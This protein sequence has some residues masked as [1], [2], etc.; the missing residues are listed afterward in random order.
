MRKQIKIKT[1][2]ISLKKALQMLKDNKE[3]LIIKI[4]QG[5]IFQ[6]GGY[7]YF[8]DFDGNIKYMSEGK[9]RSVKV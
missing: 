3:D 1:E 8:I 9:I 7:R 4:K 6:S 2:N 5:T